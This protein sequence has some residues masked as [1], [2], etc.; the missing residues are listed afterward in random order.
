MSYK[1]IYFVGKVKELKKHLKNLRRVS[2][3]HKN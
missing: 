1:I 2:Y 3:E